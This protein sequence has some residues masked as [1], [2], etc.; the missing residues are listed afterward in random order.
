MAS[1]RGRWP[2]RSA[3]RARSP[4]P[5]A[6]V[7]VSTTADIC[8][9]TYEVENKTGRIDFWDRK[10]QKLV[11]PR[12]EQL[13]QRAVRAVVFRR[14]QPHR[15]CCLE[16]ARRSGG[17]ARLSLRPARRSARSARREQPRRFDDRMPALSGDGR[18]LAFA[19]NRKGGAGLTDIYLYDRK[20]GKL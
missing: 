14:R 18:Y 3:R 8:A 4:A 19:S 5:R 10:E 16:S 2:A 1:P 6:S 9:F 20:E 15:F 7:P 11:E 12:R 17:L 13:A